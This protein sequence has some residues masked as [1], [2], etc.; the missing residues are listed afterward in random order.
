MRSCLLAA[1]ETQHDPKQR[2][3]HVPSTSL[4]PAAH[5]SCARAGTAEVPASLRESPVPCVQPGSPRSSVLSGT[6]GAAM[7]RERANAISFPLARSVQSDRSRRVRPTLRRCEYPTTEMSPHAPALGP[8]HADG[9]SRIAFASS[10]GGTTETPVLPSARHTAASKFC[11]TATFARKPAAMT[12]CRNLLASCVASPNRVVHALYVE[13]IGAG[14]CLHILD[15]W[16]KHARD[17]VKNR[18]RGDFLSGYAGDSDD[19]RERFPLQASHADFNTQHTRRFVRRKDDLCRWLT[20]DQAQ[21]VASAAPGAVA[22]RPAQRS[23]GDEE[24]RTLPH[25]RP[26]S[27]S[28]PFGPRRWFLRKERRAFIAIALAHQS[29]LLSL[30]ESGF[31]AGTEGTNIGRLTTQRECRATAGAWRL[32]EKDKSRAGLLGCETKAIP[33]RQ[34]NAHRVLWEHIAHIKHDR[35]EAS[36]LKQ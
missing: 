17:G 33:R 35:G 5:P 7:Y 6:S 25:P 11:E 13:N 34:R 20:V 4:A 27:F 36:G 1:V 16:R 31:T 15:T 12:R 18:L 3:W 30:E 26:E 14:V 10:P 2:Q 19:L 22:L 28:T 29:V 32:T 9:R 23:S 8:A 24:R 21:T